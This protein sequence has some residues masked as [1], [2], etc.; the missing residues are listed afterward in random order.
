MYLRQGWTSLELLES[1]QDMVII[2]EYIIY[3]NYMLL[4]IYS[5][6]YI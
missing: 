6:I 5:Y 3:S 1:G 4:Y 2:N